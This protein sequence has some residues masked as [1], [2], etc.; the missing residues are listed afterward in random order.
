MFHFILE[1]SPNDDWFL[2]TGPLRRYKISPRREVPK[3]IQCPDY[4]FHPEGIS[5]SE[6]SANQNKDI[7]VYTDEDIEQMKVVCKLG[8]LVLD[9]A[10]KAVQIGI[11]TD[12]LDQMFMRQQLKM[13]AIPPR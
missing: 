7:P 10:H 6:E 12:E 1:Y 9:T 11:T 4:A 5:E 8:R 13:I 3:S 2:Y